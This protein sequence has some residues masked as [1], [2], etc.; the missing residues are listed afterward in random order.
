VQQAAGSFWI[1]CEEMA[2]VLAIHLD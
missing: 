1:L 2:V